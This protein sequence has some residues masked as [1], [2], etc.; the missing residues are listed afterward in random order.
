MFLLLRVAQS[1]RISFRSELKLILA[2]ELLERGK[3]IK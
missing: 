2:R 3:Q 1:M